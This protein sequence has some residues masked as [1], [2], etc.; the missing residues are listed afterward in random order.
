MGVRRCAPQG[1]WPG[2]FALASPGEIIL[3]EQLHL[4]ELQRLRPTKLHWYIWV[5]ETEEVEAMTKLTHIYY[6]CLFLRLLHC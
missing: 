4:E 2:R 3:L 1:F 5:S 6:A